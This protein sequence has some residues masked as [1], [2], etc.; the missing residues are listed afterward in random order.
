MVYFTT[1]LQKGSTTVVALLFKVTG[2]PYTQEGFIFYLPSVAIEIAEQCSG[3]NSSLA[4][5]IVGILLS[6]YIVGTWWKKA[7]LIVFILP[8]V[9]I[10]N[11]IRIVALSFLGVHVDESILTQGFLHQSGGFIFYL[12]ALALLFTIAWILRR[13]S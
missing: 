10:K 7:I 9:L 2:M 4:L 13:A 6:H 11:A 5:L 12:P 8:I 3:I 1:L